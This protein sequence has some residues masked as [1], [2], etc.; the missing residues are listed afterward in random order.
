MKPGDAL[1]VADKLWHVPACDSVNSPSCPCV[2]RLELIWSTQHLK[3]SWRVLYNLVVFPPWPFYC[4]NHGPLTRPAPSCS[5]QHGPSMLASRLDM[6]GWSVEMLGQES[7]VCGSHDISC[8]FFLW[9][10]LLGPSKEH[11]T[12]RFWRLWLIGTL[13]HRPPTSGWNQASKMKIASKSEVPWVW[14][15]FA[16]QENVIR[17][18]N[19]TSACCLVVCTILF[20]TL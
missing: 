12:I 19:Q 4:N 16:C 15:R 20:F 7:S 9:F 2:H 1:A 6:N 18:R 17:K 14:W 8:L 10:W 13:T 3:S 5:S 11:Q